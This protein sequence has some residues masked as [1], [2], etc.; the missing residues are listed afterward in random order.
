MTEEEW[1]EMKRHPVVGAELIK[2]I[3]Y[4]AIAIPVIRHHHERWDGKGY[5]DGLKGEEIPLAARIVMVADALDAM[6]TSRAYQR[7]SSPD[8]AYEEIV[9]CAGTV[10]DPKVVEA[11]KNC[12]HEIK[13]IMP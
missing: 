6:T 8:E 13:A 12:W 1:A 10:Y 5:P 9:K 2:N 3:P 11:L 4:L 7:K